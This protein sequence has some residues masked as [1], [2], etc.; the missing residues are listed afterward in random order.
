[1]KCL[2]RRLLVIS[3][4]LLFLTPARSQSDQCAV[5]QVTGVN[6]SANNCNQFITLI[7]PYFGSNQ[8]CLEPYWVFCCNTEY[9][10]YTDSGFYCSEICDDAVKAILKD[11]SL[12][13]FAM[14]HT[15]WAKDCSGHFS[16]LARSW[17]V[18]QKPLDL[19]PRLSLSGIGG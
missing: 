19:R 14:T 18:T 10:D 2:F 5:P 17:D 4:V 8:T 9:L 1:M 7:R 6:C 3:S 12:S 11:P 15:L 16:P 13:E